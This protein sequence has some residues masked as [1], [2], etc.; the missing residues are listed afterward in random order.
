MMKISTN[1]RMSFYAL[2]VAGRE[3]LSTT[4]KA[5]F[6]CIVQPERAGTTVELPDG[7]RDGDEPGVPPS[8]RS[9][10]LVREQKDGLVILQ[11]FELA[12]LLDESSHF[13]VLIDDELAAT[14]AYA[15]VLSGKRED[16]GHALW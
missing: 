9:G 3:V 15:S 13:D 1:E 10:T 6:E 7:P 16:D 12:N 2:Q 14:E 5:G 8:I 11:P 4:A